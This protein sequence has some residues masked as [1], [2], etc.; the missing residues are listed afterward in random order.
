MCVNGAPSPATLL[1]LQAKARKNIVTLATE[2]IGEENIASN[3][4]MR[5]YSHGGVVRDRVTQVVIRL[6]DDIAPF[7]AIHFRV[8]AAAQRLGRNIHRCYAPAN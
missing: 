5:F 2:S 6:Y 8:A 4:I 7:N 1:T 3:V